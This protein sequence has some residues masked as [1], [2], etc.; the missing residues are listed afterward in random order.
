MDYPLADHAATGSFQPVFQGSVRFVN[1]HTQ[2]LTP[3][4]LGRE[5]NTILQRVAFPSTT[6][7]YFGRLG[8]TASP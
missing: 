7:T 6:P 2:S 1:W 3:T 8:V 4:A 5:G